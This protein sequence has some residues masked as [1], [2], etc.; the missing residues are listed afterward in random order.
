MRDGLLDG[1]EVVVANDRGRF[2]AR[3][4]VGDTGRPGLATI[5]KGWWPQHVNATVREADSDMGHGAVFH[6]NV[7]SITKVD[8]PGTADRV[9]PGVRSEAAT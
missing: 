7:V 5:T 3:V 8:P 9:E 1:D 4:A 2:V 6:D